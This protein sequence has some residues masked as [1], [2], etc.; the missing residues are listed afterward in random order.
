MW[1]FKREKGGQDHRY[2][3]TTEEPARPGLSKR[4]PQV[5]PKHQE[6]FSKNG[7]QLTGLIENMKHISRDSLDRV[8]ELKDSL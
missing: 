6:K 1:P 4:Q 7:R 3:R 8:R 5:D 2:H